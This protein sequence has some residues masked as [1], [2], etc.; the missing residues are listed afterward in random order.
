VDIDEPAAYARCM[1]KELSGLDATAQAELVRSGEVAP[2]DLV[3]A[4][5]GRIEAVNPRLNAVIH[6]LFEKARSAAKSTSLPK[7]PFRGVPYLLK[8]LDC[9]SAGDPFHA[10]MAFLKKVK[11]IARHDSYLVAKLRAAGFVIVGK[12]NTPELGLN[13]TTE[14]ASYGPSRNPWNTEHSTGGSSGGSAAAVASGMVPAAHA[15]DGGGSIRIPA[16]ECG[17]VGLKPTR[18]R[19]SLGPDYGEYWHG[20]VNSHAVTR[21]VRDSAAILDATLGPM[22]GDPY[23]APP[24]ARPY[25]EEVGAAPG[26]LRVGVLARFADLHPECA[27][28]A[29]DAAGLLASLGHHVEETYPAALDEGDDTARNFTILVAAWVATTLAEWSEITGAEIGAGDV[30]PMTWGLAEMGRVCNAPMYLRAVEWMHGYSRRMA[31]WWDEGF[32]VLITPTLAGPPPRIG[33][34]APP[35]DNPLDLGKTMKLIPFT[36]PFNITGQPAMSLPL[37]WTTTGLPIGVQFVGAYGREDLLFR[38]AAQVEEA[39]PWGGK[40]PSVHA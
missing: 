22:P 37:G 31:A 6:P 4:A 3:E 2:I 15:S 33:E 16:S 7:G 19:L 24:P 1:I 40:R 14:P 27:D 21:S 20:L 18:G 35:A 25:A 36:A 34:L 12:T 9:T 17:L 8:D 10:G 32:D 26:R 5:I 28:A 11:W 39:R 29:R 23:T 30:E 13:I 38:L